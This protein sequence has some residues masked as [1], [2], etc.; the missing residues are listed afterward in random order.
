M[1]TDRGPEIQQRLEKFLDD[2][3]DVTPNE[4]R[5][6]L[7]GEGWDES[8][9]EFFAQ[10]PSDTQFLLHEIQRLTGELHSTRSEL[11]AIAAIVSDRSEAGTYAKVDALEQERERLTGELAQ[12]RKELREQD[13]E[14]DR[15]TRELLQ[16]QGELAHIKA[17][18]A[19]PGDETPP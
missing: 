4:L 1:S 15:L 8:V 7:R 5:E 13:V 19:A 12:A 17:A 14:A 10:A 11:E 9:V 2:A 18:L 16:A 6:D 3:G